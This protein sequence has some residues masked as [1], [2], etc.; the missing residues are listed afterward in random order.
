MTKHFDV[1]NV[2][3]AFLNHQHPEDSV[4]AELIKELG[5]AVRY[6]AKPIQLLVAQVAQECLEQ[7]GCTPEITVRIALMYGLVLGVLAERDRAERGRKFVI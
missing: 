6:P 7:E 3:A 4:R 1:T 5:E 2:V